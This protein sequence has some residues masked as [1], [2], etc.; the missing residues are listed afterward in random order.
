MLCRN[1]ILPDVSLLRQTI[2][3]RKTEVAENFRKTRVY[4]LFLP[5]FPQNSVDQRSE[6]KD[7]LLP[8]WKFE[9]NQL[10]KVAPGFKWHISVAI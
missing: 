4:R 10:D 6:L 8:V 9:E 7:A 3:L 1:D 5:D 2:S